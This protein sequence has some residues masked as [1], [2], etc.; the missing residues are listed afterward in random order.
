MDRKELEAEL[1]NWDPDITV[2]VRARTAATLLGVCPQ[3]VH[4]LGAE[5]GARHDAGVKYFR[6]DLVRLLAATR[7]ARIDAARSRK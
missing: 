4:Q 2:W 3:R 7:R 6:L 5:L 1:Y